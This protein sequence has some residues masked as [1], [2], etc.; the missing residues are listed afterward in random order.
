M[1]FALIAATATRLLT[2]SSLPPVATAAMFPQGPPL[3]SLRLANISDVPRIAVVAT[4]GFY[5]SPVFEW[6]RPSHRDYP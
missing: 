4:A 5:Y 6:E 3:G 1:M 2:W